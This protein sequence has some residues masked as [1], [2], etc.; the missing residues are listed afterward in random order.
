MKSLM[1]LKKIFAVAYGCFRAMCLLK[2]VPDDPDPGNYFDQQSS[3]VTFYLKVF[4]FFIIIL[5]S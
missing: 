3:S 2:D 1:L 4:N 5:F